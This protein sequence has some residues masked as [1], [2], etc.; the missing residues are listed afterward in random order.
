MGITGTISLLDHKTY[1]RARLGLSNPIKE[2]P[3]TKDH[4]HTKQQAKL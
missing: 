1:N 2:M 4:R 3:S